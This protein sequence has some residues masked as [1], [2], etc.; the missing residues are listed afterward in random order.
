MREDFTTDQEIAVLKI[1]GVQ[2]LCSD[3]WYGNMQIWVT[4]EFTI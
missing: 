4:D 2:T 3:K 1:R